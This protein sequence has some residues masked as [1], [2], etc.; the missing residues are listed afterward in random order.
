MPHPQ[1]TAMAA[2]SAGSSRR[3]GTSAGAACDMAWF[4]Q[5]R[6][7]RL[8]PAAAIEKHSEPGMK[9]SSGFFSTGSAPKAHT[10]P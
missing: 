7:A 5:L 2:T 8:Q 10:L 4:W 9:C 6:H 1:A 3:D